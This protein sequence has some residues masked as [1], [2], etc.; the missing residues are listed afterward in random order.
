MPPRV[1]KNAIVA[2]AQDM[3]EIAGKLL[4]WMKG[5]LWAQ[6]LQRRKSPCQQLQR[7]HSISGSELGAPTILAGIGG[8]RKPEKAAGIRHRLHPARRLRRAR[9]KSLRAQR[10][11]RCKSPCQRLQSHDSIRGG[12][13]QLGAPDML[14][15]IGGTQKPVKAAGIRHGLHPA[16][17]VRRASHTTPLATLRQA[18]VNCNRALARLRPANR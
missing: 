2:G 10:L 15:C 1:V 4:A 11:Q 8:T 5:A 3:P 9:R 6:G 14:A 17:R 7:H 13:S 12:G 18:S 16:R